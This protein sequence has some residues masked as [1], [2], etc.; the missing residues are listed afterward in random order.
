MH[1]WARWL[2]FVLVDLYVGFSD[3]TYLPFDRT[4]LHANMCEANG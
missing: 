1:M 2:F 3:N 4:E